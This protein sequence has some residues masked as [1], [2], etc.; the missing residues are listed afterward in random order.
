MA[1]TVLRI[2]RKTNSK[3]IHYLYHCGE[4]SM[5]FSGMKVN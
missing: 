5:G 3:I 1:R 2:A 4:E